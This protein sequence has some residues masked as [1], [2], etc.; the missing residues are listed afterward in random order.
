[1]TILE[2]IRERHSV[3][4]YQDLPIEEVKVSQIK[5]KMAELMEQSGLKMELFTNEPEAFE[6]NKPHYGSFVGCKN[7]MTISGKADQKEACGYYGEQL[8]L[9]CQML[10]LNTCWVALT[11]KKSAI[12]LELAKNEKLLIVLSL[13]YG[14]TPGVQH[15]SKRIDQVAKITDD[16]PEWFKKGVEAALLA[17]T[18]INQQQFYFELVDGNKV[19]AKAKFGPC[20]IIDLGI[21]KYHFEVGAGR[22]HFT[23]SA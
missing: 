9:F 17:P 16:T 21:V 19:K 14:Q 4:K 22:E 3:R 8:V 10:G 7:Y 23:W 18:A 11:F 20:N 1:M 13:G 12:K 5:Q 15:K 2:A 6:G